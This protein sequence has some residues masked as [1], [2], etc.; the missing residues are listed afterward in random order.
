MWE[1]DERLYREDEI[2]DCPTCDSWKIKTQKVCSLCAI[3]ARV[4][5]HDWRPLG[6]IGTL[7]FVFSRKPR[8]ASW[9]HFG[10]ELTVE[11]VPDGNTAWIERIR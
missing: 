5:P 3:K 7:R 6:V 8:A 4:T 11:R 10:F 1:A 9:R 2:D